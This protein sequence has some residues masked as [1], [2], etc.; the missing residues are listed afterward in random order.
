[1]Y[2]DKKES[3]K[4]LVMESMENALSKVSQLESN[5]DYL[6]RRFE[7][8]NTKLEC[9]LRELRGDNNPVYHRSESQ[10]PLEKNSY[11]R[12]DI[13]NAFVRTKFYEGI[14][15]ELGG[16]ILDTLITILDNKHHS[17]KK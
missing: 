11:T 8:Q 14:S 7:E 17:Q 4:S 15:P 13:W 12:E 2:E 3:V 10:N 16:T 1:M 5:H 6:M 9:A